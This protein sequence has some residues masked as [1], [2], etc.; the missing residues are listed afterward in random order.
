MEIDETKRISMFELALLPYFQRI[1]KKEPYNSNNIHGSAHDLRVR[2]P[3]YNG[4]S[5]KV[6]KS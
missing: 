6:P 3:S 2:A 1:S 5:S 4:E